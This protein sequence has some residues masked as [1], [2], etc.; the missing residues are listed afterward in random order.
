MGKHRALNII[1]SLLAGLAIFVWLVLMCRTAGGVGV[2]ELSLIAVVACG[3]AYLVGTRRPAGRS[4]PV[5][6]RT[7]RVTP[8]AASN[9]STTRSN[10]EPDSLARRYSP[11]GRTASTGPNPTAAAIS[12]SEL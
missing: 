11:R 9:P 5:M 8:E 2:F 12:R 6:A 10:W 1:V 7:I 3:G 4:Q